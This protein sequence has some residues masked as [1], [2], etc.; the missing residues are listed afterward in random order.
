MN[1]KPLNGNTQYAMAA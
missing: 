1:T